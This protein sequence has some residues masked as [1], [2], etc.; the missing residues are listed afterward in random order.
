MTIMGKFREELQ[1]QISR[2]G[3]QGRP[4]VEIN[5]GELHCIVS[6]D[7]NRY[8]MVCKAMR[9]LQ[10]P[11]DEVIHAPPAGD[12]PSLTIRYVLPRA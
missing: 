4:H 8:P 2:A 10:G 1:A 3:N 6:P 5:A 11:S 12:G 7:A 9:Q